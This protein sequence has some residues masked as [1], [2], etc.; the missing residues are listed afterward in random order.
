MIADG[1][2]LTIWGPRLPQHTITVQ[3][4]DPITRKWE[5]APLTAPNTFQWDVP[6]NE[7]VRVAPN[8][9]VYTYFRITFTKSAAPGAWHFSPIVPTSYELRNAKGYDDIA[10]LDVQEPE[11]SL[12]VRS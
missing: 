3:W 8:H 1:F 11:L 9:W 7:S 6:L 4:L 10:G 5:T 12:T 2:A